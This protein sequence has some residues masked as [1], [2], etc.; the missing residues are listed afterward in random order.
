MAIWPSTG[1]GYAMGFVFGGAFVA[2]FLGG[3]TILQDRVHDAVRGRAF[4]IAHSA[5]R[6]GAVAVGLLAAWG[7]KMLGSGHVLGNMDGTQ[8]VLGC[9]GLT[10]FVAGAMLVRPTLR[11]A[12]TPA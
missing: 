3:I 10:L 5:L 7:A 11:A 9:A 12:R 6:V 4:A 8:V 1:V 2:T